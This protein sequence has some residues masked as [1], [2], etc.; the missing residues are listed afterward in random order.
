MNLT[1]KIVSTLLITFGLFA[2]MF[3]DKLAGW[4]GRTWVLII[5]ALLI[6]YFISWTA[7][8]GAPR[9]YYIEYVSLALYGIGIGISLGL[10]YFLG[11]YGQT[12][13]IIVGCLCALAVIQMYKRYCRGDYVL[14]YLVPRGRKK[15]SD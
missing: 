14:L 3:F 12:S 7:K 5:P 8:N 9:S 6:L 11:K 10:I 15:E 1:L 2:G 13:V 4:W